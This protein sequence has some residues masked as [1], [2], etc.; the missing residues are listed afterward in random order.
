MHRTLLFVIGVFAV[1]A[2]IFALKNSGDAAE[3]ISQASQG[4][5]EK[6]A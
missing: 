2:S 6:R 4:T 5:D 3:P 1:A